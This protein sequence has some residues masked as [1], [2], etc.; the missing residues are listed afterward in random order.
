LHAHIGV[1][2]I[3]SAPTANYC[4]IVSQLEP[5][6]NIPSHDAGWEDYE[7]L[8]DPLGEANGPPISDNEV[9]LQVLTQT[10]TGE[11][12]LVFEGRYLDARAPLGG[13][14][15]ASFRRAAWIFISPFFERRQAADSR[16]HA[17][18]RCIERRIR[19]RL[20]KQTN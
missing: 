20:S 12:R 3:S 2:L 11:N 4:E 17:R 15:D 14:F 13:G 9:E 5:A 8:L 10:S 19:F 1:H 6:T 16:G 7:D 18:H